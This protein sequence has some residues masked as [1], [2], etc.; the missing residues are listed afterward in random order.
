MRSWIKLRNTTESIEPSEALSY[1]VRFSKEVHK[2]D[3]RLKENHFTPKM[4]PYVKSVFRTDR[5]KGNEI[6]QAEERVMLNS[7]K[8]SIFATAYFDEIMV[9]SARHNGNTL[10]VVPEE[11]QYKWHADICGW[12]EG[13]DPLAKAARTHL[14]QQLL[15]YATPVVLK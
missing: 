9:G 10:D 7:G 11:S 15:R 2:K 4:S 5:M 13:T 6:D 3:N 1:F 14:S 8:S 12:P